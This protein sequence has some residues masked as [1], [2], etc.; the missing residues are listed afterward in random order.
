MVCLHLGDALSLKVY[1]T[2]SNAA[3]CI[4]IIFLKGFGAAA[5]RPTPLLLSQAKP[6]LVVGL[7]SYHLRVAELEKYDFLRRR[8]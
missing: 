5:G 4:I 6:V 3:R 7:K 8:L 2:M 1:P